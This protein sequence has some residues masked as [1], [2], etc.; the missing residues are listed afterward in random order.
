MQRRWLGV[1]GSLVLASNAAAQLEITCSVPG[2]FIDISGT[3]TALGLDDEGVAEITPGFDL[4]TTLFAGDGTGRVWVSNNGAVGFLGDEGSAGA[5]YLNTDLPNFALFGGS[6]GVPQ[7]L[8]VYWD[9]LDSDTGDVYY[10]T[11]GDPGSRVLIIQWQDRPHY[12]GDA[13]I[14]GDEAT[15]QVQVFED[16]SSGYAQLLFEDVDFQDPALDNGASATIGYQAG[17][18]GNTVQ[19]SFNTPGSVQAGDVLTLRDVGDVDGDGTVGIND[20]LDLLG[21]WGPCA[22]VCACAADFD[23]DSEVGIT[24]FLTLLGCWD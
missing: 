14:D 3:G 20:F 22:D 7:A 21:G 2:T 16:A 23:G 8:A 18:I 1:L 13:V 11:I 19:W 17:G 6:H 12:P 15:F 4:T 9:D 10:E 5:F 24:D